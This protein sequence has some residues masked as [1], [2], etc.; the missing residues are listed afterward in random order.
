MERRTRRRFRK[1]ASNQ[2]ADDGSADAQK[3]RHDETEMLHPGMIARAMRPMMKP[4]MMDQMM[5]NIVLLLETARLS[6]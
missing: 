6:R 2:A 1:K 4:I 5:C 3:C